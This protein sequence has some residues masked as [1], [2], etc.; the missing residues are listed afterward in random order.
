MKDE[1]ATENLES[2]K[3]RVKKL[4]ALSK[5]P[6]EAEAESAMR[7]ANELM[8]AYKISQK[9]ISA[10]ISKSVKGTKRVSLWRTILANAVENV[11][12]TCHY[13]TSDGKV[14]FYGEELDVFMATEMYTYLCKTI[15]RMAK[16][17]I[18]KNAKY[19]YRQ[20][21]RKGIADQLWNRM[22]YLGWNCSWRSPEELDTQK[23]AVQEFVN[24][25]VK[26]KTIQPI[27]KKTEISTAYNRGKI[28]ANGV[29]L[30]RQM[31]GNGTRSIEGC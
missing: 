31:T 27:K 16:Q 15:D 2:V 3:R 22:F 24:T 17:N 25:M 8:T 14:I 9:E 4:L 1:S 23:K 20:S 11:Y 7:K 30:A 26:L 18:R 19:N 10:F 5:S 21:Y 12:A 13:G 28:D 6:H 29:S